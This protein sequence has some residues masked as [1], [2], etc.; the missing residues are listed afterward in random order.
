MYGKHFA[1]MYSGSM[2]GAGLNVFAVWGY[3]VANTTKSRVELNPRLLAAILGC[4]EEEVT[5]AIDY[6]M[7]PDPQSRLKDH[8]GKRLIREGQYQYFV[9]AYETYHNIRNEDERREYNR[10]KQRESR[11]KRCP[12][13]ENVN[14]SQT[15]SAHKE[16]EADTEKEKTPPLSPPKGGKSGKVDLNDVRLLKLA[17][18]IQAEWNEMAETWR[19]F[20]IPGIKKFSDKRLKTLAE[21]MKDPF[22]MKNAKAAM[23]KII[24]VPY[25]R[26]DKGDWRANIDF[27]LTQDGVLKVMEGKYGPESDPENRLVVDE[28]GNIPGHGLV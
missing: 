24:R 11:A 27:L 21:R 8:S 17:A 7:R 14:D 13:K 20:K 25:L 22:W 26:G 16:A 10:L 9:P 15:M 19:E 5:A 6:L 2:V 1:S 4:E 28:N 12:V 18:M 23:W 3:V